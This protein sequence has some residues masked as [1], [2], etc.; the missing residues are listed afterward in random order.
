[1][2][3]KKLNISNKKQNFSSHHH[4][5][6]EKGQLG[7]LKKGEKYRFQWSKNFSKGGKKI[8]MVREKLWV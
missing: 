6:L 3:K 5:H 1:M 8:K 4:K 2:H 7:N